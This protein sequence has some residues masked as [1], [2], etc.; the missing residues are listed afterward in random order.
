[1]L[2]PGQVP[3]LVDVEVIAFP[4][5]MV[6]AVVVPAQFCASV[7]EIVYVPGASPVNVPVELGPGS[8]PEPL[9]VNVKGAVPKSGVAVAVPS[10]TLGQVQLVKVMFE[11]RLLTAVTVTVIVF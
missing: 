6:T 1:L 10:F 8:V 5:P 11:G 7:K 4:A 9:M 2:N 3:V